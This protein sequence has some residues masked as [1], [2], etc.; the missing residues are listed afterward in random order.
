VLSL[1]VR[2]TDPRVEKG[3]AEHSLTRPG[4]ERREVE[5]V[6]HIDEID[7][8]NIAIRPLLDL[9]DQEVVAVD[10]APG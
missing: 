10:Q 7:V 9:H 3:F 5:E 6:Q 8:R 2:L 4:G 1:F